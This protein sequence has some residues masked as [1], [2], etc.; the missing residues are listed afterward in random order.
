MLI[1]LQQNAATA[2]KSSPDLRIRSNYF[3]VPS[4]GWYHYFPIRVTPQPAGQ[5]KP[6]FRIEKGPVL[7]R[8]GYAII[9]RKVYAVTPDD[10]FRGVVR[11]SRLVKVKRSRNQDGTFQHHIVTG[12][13]ADS[14]TDAPVSEPDRQPIA[15]DTAWLEVIQS[16][17]AAWAEQV[18]TLRDTLSEKEGGEW[19]VE[20]PA[21]SGRGNESGAVQDTDEVIGTD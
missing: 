19:E 10:V 4:H 6:V 13:A 18:N 12:S 7:I 20:N 8:E 14:S 16:A 1:E 2:T 11:R 21:Q 15:S 9:D 17:D 3:V 5:E